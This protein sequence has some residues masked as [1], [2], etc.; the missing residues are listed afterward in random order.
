MKVKKELPELDKNFVYMQFGLFKEFIM[1]YLNELH[2][3][4]QLFKSISRYYNTMQSSET[5]L[6][7]DSNYL[8]LL[9]YAVGIKSED[10][11]SLFVDIVQ[12][13]CFSHMTSTYDNQNEIDN[14]VQ[15]VFD[16]VHN[17]YYEVK[18]DRNIEKLFDIAVFYSYLDTEYLLMR[19][20][21]DS[22]RNK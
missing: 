11:Q 13:F 20:K 1:G 12:E 16:P 7:L 18:T 22:K 17:I 5:G 6:R 8:Y 3:Q 19:E 15:E 4:K 14:L 21:L 2:A 10:L 9:A